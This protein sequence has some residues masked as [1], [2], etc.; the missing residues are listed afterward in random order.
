MQEIR[1]RQ[2]R[3]KDRAID[4]ATWIRELLTRAPVGTLASVSED[5]APAIVPNL[6]AFDP[7]NDVVYLHSAKQ[8]ETRTN[9]ELRPRVAF[10]VSE[11]GRLLP[12]GAAVDFSVEFASVILGGTSSVVDDPAEARHAL[13]LL[14]RK[15]APNLEPERHYRGI[16]DRD[17]ARTSVYRI[18]I[19]SWSGKGKSSTAADAYTYDPPSSSGFR[20]AIRATL[21]ERAR[22]DG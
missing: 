16:G 1:F 20:S 4:D 3:R 11:M 5:G 19:E 8:G 10:S 18:D 12:A 7:T 9:V 14:M 15:Y 21:C 17:L 13:E 2:P 6:F 22:G